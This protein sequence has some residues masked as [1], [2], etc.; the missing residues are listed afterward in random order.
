MLSPN[1]KY[2]RIDTH[3]DELSFFS[4]SHKMQGAL[5]RNKPTLTY[6]NTIWHTWPW[7]QQDQVSFGFPLWWVSLP[8]HKQWQTTTL[9]YIEPKFT[10]STSK[11][12]NSLMILI[13]SFVLLPYYF[14]FCVDNKPNHSHSRR[15]W[16]NKNI[17]VKNIHV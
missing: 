5:T 17:H 4:I 15:K 14:K 16:E 6:I 12:S 2:Q 7:Q 10:K 3:F 8:R 11:L 9:G 13:I 1:T